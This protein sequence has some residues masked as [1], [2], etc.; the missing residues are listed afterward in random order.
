M[1]AS[2]AKVAARWLGLQFIK[3]GYIAASPGKAD[4][5]STVNAVLALAAAD[6]GGSRAHAAMTWLEGHFGSYVT[7]SGV[8]DPGRLATLILAAVAMGVNPRR[9]GGSKPA[10]NLVAR[11]RATQQTKGADAGLFGTADPT[12]DGTYREG[13]SLL[14]LSSVGLRNLAAVSWLKAQQCADGGWTAY[15]KNVKIRCAAPD[16]ATYAGPDTNSTALA[17]EALAAVGARFPHSPVAF[18]KAAQEP[19]GGFGYIGIAGHGQ[20]SDADSTALSIQALVALRVLG[21]GK[22]AKKGGTPMKA[23]LRFQ[24]GCSSPASQRG[25][26]AF[27]PTGSKLEPNLL[28]T[29][30][31][32]PAAARRAFPLKAQRLADTLPTMTCP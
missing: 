9:F 4:A 1:P 25:A 27:Q 28:A 21:T 11:L 13:L 5:G 14:A 31:A 10:D 20:A 18:F 2:A 3:A 17:V 15:R 24:L 32:V 12:F 16:P 22:F 7:V 19:D 6:V 29:L 23:L 26:F 30:Q 8:D